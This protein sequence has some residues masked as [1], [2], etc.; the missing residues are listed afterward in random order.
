MLSKLPRID[1]EVKRTIIAET[2]K[3][4]RTGVLVDAEHALDFVCVKKLDMDNRLV[5]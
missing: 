5:S 4:R 2:Q 1:F 3:P